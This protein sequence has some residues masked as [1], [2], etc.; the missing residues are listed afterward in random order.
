MAQPRYETIDFAV[1]LASVLR[2]A[3]IKANA[4]SEAIGE[5]EGYISWLMNQA[6][7]IPVDVVN[8]ISVALADMTGVDWRDIA[9]YLAGISDV[10]PDVSSTPP[11]SDMGGKVSAPVRF[12]SVSATL[13][14]AA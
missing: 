10:E 14:H 1:R 4:L 3:R 7:S 8:R 13:A 6:K 5:K 11:R 12:R 9:Q 2:R